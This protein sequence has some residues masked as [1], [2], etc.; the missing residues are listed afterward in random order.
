MKWTFLVFSQ[1]TG[2]VRPT[3]ALIPLVQEITG[4]KLQVNEEKA[5]DMI[6]RS[7]WFYSIWDEIFIQE[8]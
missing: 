4:I 8:K 6:E 5:T 7:W 1:N 3:V 2:P